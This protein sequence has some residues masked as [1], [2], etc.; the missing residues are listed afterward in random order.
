MSSLRVDSNFLAAIDL[1]F[2]IPGNHD[3]EQSTVC[4]D[5]F[6]WPGSKSGRFDLFYLTQIDLLTGHEWL[7]LEGHEK[8]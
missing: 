5:A 1:A 3:H 2:R 8:L 4:I 6:I 7:D